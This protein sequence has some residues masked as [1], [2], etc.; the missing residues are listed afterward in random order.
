MILQFADLSRVLIPHTRH[1][2]KSRSPPFE[3]SDTHLFDRDLPSSTT[4]GTWTRLPQSTQLPLRRPPIQWLRTPTQIWNFPPQ[5]DKKPGKWLVQ[6]IFDTGD[7]QPIYRIMNFKPE[8]GYFRWKWIKWNAYSSSCRF[9]FTRMYS[10]NSNTLFF[11][12]WGTADGKGKK[13]HVT[14]MTY[15]NVCPSIHTNLQYLQKLSSY[16]YLE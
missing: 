12:L 16:T 7:P 10:C 4:H 13:R 1:Q 3:P 9:P 15:I 14:H 8:V 6:P 5:R 2:C 11:H